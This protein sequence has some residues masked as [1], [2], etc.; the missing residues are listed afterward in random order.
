MLGARSTPVAGRP[1]IA[2]PPG[3]AHINLIILLMIEISNDIYIG[4]A[5]TGDFYQDDN[6]FFVIVMSPCFSR[7]R[8]LAVTVTNFFTFD[9]MNLQEM[10]V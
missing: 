7:L 5:R 1:G 8:A 3:S 2:V 4:I 10:A 6:K 9:K